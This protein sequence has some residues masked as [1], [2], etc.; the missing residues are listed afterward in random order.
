MVSIFLIGTEVVDQ[1]FSLSQ[2]FCW[3]LS[4]L[5]SN[6]RCVVPQVVCCASR[7]GLGTH[8]PTPTSAQWDTPQ[9]TKSPI[10]NYP[11]GR[12]F[13]CDRSLASS[14]PSEHG[15]WLAYQ[16]LHWKS[17]CVAECVQIFDVALTGTVLAAD[18]FQDPVPSSLLIQTPLL[19]CFPRIKLFTRKYRLDWLGFAYSCASFHLMI[20]KPL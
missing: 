5:K 6:E 3:F 7:L 13:S 12:S 17:A 16:V 9:S 14:L 1:L 8:S 15:D 10:S 11:L 20:W 19:S 2:A 18:A 4:F